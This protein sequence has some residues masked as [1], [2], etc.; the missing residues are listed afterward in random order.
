MSVAQAV[1]CRFAGLSAGQRVNVSGR[2]YILAGGGTGGHLFPGIAVAECVTERHPRAR[3][4]FV[5]SDRPIERDILAETPFDHHRLPSVSFDSAGRHPLRFAARTWRA[6]RAASRLIEEVCPQAVIGCGGFASAAP[7]LAARK[8]GVPFL[9]LEQNVIPGRATRWLSRL[10]GTV[11]LTYERTASLLP[12]SVQPVVTGNP[13]R[14]DIARLAGHAA[15]RQGQTLLVLGGSQGAK[16]INDLMLAVAAD[17][18]AALD[19]W[20]I[21]HQTGLRDEERVR[22]G[23]SAG[24]I[25]ATVS[26][27][28]ADMPGLYEQA[29]VVVSRAGGTTLSELAC[30][31]LPSVLLPY[32][33]AVANHQWHNAELFR[34]AGASILVDE[35]ADD[36][37]AVPHFA[38]AVGSLLS[39]PTLRQT[40]CAAVSKLACPDAADTV[41]TLLDAITARGDGTA[42][43]QRMT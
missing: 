41:V 19:G 38:E 13:V 4:L 16:R 31:G 36:S 32:P 5:G 10:G 37:R 22:L 7:I 24:N 34:A 6:Y 17:R 20:R 14:C 21:I 23:Y 35:W 11:C 29:D 30:A 33:H 43:S 25:E 3:V 39:D 40:M 27:F 1:T 18:R 8:R 2:T 9:L 15:P 42:S 12:A 26:A 28:Y